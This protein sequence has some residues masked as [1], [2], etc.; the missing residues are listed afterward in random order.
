MIY[1]SE[2]TASQS[3]GRMNSWKPCS[4]PPFSLPAW[5]NYAV[6]EPLPHAC[7]QGRASRKIADMLGFPLPAFALARRIPATARKRGANFAGMTSP[8][9]YLFPFPQLMNCPIP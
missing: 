4:V 8:T 9:T 6:V 7:R 2:N 3:V 5:D 1:F